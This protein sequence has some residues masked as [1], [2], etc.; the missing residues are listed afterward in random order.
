MMFNLIARKK[1][2]ERIAIGGAI[3]QDLPRECVR[4]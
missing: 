3:G 1:I 2:S 4:L